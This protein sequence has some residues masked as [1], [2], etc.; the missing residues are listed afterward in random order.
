MVDDAK[1]K[2]IS[3]IMKRFSEVDGVGIVSYDVWGEK[4]YIFVVIYDE[5]DGEE[6]RRRLSEVE[7]GV[8]KD[9]SE[10]DLEFCYI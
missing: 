4:V 8:L 3:K 10:L 5:M 6:L 2:V 9:F 1:W 7:Q